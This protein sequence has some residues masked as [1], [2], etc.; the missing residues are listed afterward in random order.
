MT[1]Q[2]DASLKA[3]GEVTPLI[4]RNVSHAVNTIVSLQMFPVGCLELVLTGILLP[5]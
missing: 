5:C 2:R 1:E 4:H 3:E